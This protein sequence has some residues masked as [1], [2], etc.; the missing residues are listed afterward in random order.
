[1]ILFVSTKIKL[2]NVKNI[3]FIVVKYFLC[4]SPLY[5]LVNEKLFACVKHLP[6]VTSELGSNSL[7]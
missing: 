4:Y 3:K 5:N 7:K 2:I 1:M 6:S